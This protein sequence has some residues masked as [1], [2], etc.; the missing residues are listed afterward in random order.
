MKYEL[1]EKEFLEA[2]YL[3]KHVFSEALQAVDRQEARRM[4][5]QE[6]REIREDAAEERREARSGIRVSKSEPK[7]E[8]KPE[9]WEWPD[10]SDD[11]EQFELRTDPRPEESFETKF[12]DADHEV[13]D[14]QAPADK[15]QAEVEAFG[16]E[17]FHKG[18]SVFGA[19]VNAWIVG[20]SLDDKAAPLPGVEQPD[21]G[22]LIRDLANGSNVLNVLA[23][24]GKCG[25]LT[26]A[27]DHALPPASMYLDERTR[28]AFVQAV[29]TVVCAT[30]SLLF[31][32]LSDHYE[33][34]DIYK[35]KP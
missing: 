29:A 33:H 11:D 24:V 28:R 19:F 17:R 31:P 5:A 6:R 23:H 9:P 14:V 27:I 32:E 7:P 26:H 22:E 15:V 35:G 3:V 1:S 12:D 30:A 10:E 8:P 13:D 2:L 16:A 18:A 25:G 34:R 20:L 4:A 21:R